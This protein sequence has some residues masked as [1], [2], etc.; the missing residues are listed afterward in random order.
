MHANHDLYAI[1]VFLS[2]IAAVVMQE[3]AIKWVIATHELAE[4]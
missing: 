2:P 1:E 4:R 3:L